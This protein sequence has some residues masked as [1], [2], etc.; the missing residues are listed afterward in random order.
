MAKIIRKLRNLLDKAEYSEKKGEYKANNLRD[1]EEIYEKIVSYNNYDDLFSNI[2]KDF[3]KIL[4]GYKLNNRELQELI[5][6][7]EREFRPEHG[8]PLS[9]LINISPNKRI[10]IEITKPYNDLGLFNYRKEIEIKGNV[11][12]GIGGY[13]KGGRIVVN[14]NAKDF[15]GMWMKGGEIII[16]GNAGFGAGTHMK[17]GRI[18]IEGLAKGSIGLEMEGGE[19]YIGKFPSFSVIYDD[20]PLL[21][22]LN[23]SERTKRG[24]IYKGIPPNAELVWKDGKVVI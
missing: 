23:I 17:G 19:I 18:V 1:I 24:K 6:K 15:A 22:I 2:Y 16:K 8:I 3:T 4:G 20:Q 14:G 12:A 5:Y 13:M 11:G 10:E 21:E 7:L 9:A